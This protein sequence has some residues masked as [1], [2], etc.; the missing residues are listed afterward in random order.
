MRRAYTM[1]ERRTN[2]GRPGGPTGQQGRGLARQ[3][4]PAELVRYGGAPT[5]FDLMRRFTEDVDRLFASFGLGGGPLETTRSAGSQ[6]TGLAN[7]NW[8]PSV[9]VFVRG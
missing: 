5:P 6:A 4:M 7:I 1:T 8:I 9:D 2:E 3:Q